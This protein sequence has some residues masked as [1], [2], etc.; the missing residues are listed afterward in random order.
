LE[1]RKRFYPE[2][3]DALTMYKEIDFSNER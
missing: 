3:Q 2:G 1:T